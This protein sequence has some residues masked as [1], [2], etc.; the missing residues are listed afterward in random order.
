MPQ[1]VSA[2]QTTGE[3]SY[4]S[5]WWAL[6]QVISWDRVSLTSWLL[7]WGNKLQILSSELRLLPTQFPVVL[8]ER[9]W[10]I[11]GMIPWET[12]NYKFPWA[13]SK[14]HQNLLK[15]YVS[16]WQQEDKSF[17]WIQDEAVFFLSWI[18]TVHFM[19]WLWQ[20]LWNN[21]VL[22][23]LWGKPSPCYFLL[24]SP[25]PLPAGGCS[26]E[27]LWHKHTACCDSWFCSCHC[28]WMTSVTSGKTR[29][30]FLFFLKYIH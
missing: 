28:V 6:F 18:S 13:C 22:C 7:Q 2:H 8:W 15:T 19:D 26:S 29:K 21:D 11:T 23:A 20:C 24:C 25:C 17:N 12:Q 9:A 27:F 5:H 3:F 10:P 1:I 16:I 30:I 4:N 14:S